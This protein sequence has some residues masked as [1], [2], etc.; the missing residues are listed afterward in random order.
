MLESKDYID[1][2]T[3]NDIP[4]I[5]KIV[6]NL[7]NEPLKDAD[8]IREKIYQFSTYV[9]M[10]NLN[11]SFDLNNFDQYEEYAK[12]IDNILKNPNLNRMMSLYILL[13]ILLRGNLNAKQNP[14]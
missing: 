5:F 4:N 6:H 3:K 9:Q 12:K 11:D 2:V 7:Y 14:M 10:K 8:F 13:G 1:L